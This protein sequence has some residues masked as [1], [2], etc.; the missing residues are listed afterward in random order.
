M[1]SLGAVGCNPK[2]RQMHTTAVCDKPLIRHRTAAPVACTRGGFSQPSFNH[3]LAMASSNV[4]G[5]T[6]RGSSKQPV[7]TLRAKR[8]RHLPT[9][10][11]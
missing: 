8:V 7:Q 2:A 10:C 3:L 5:A 1:E 6:G 11:A 9:V 4:H